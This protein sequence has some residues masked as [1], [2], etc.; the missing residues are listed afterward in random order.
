MISF[1]VAQFL[2]QAKET[3]TD[4]TLFFTQNLD[5]ILQ[6]MPVFLFVYLILAFFVAYKFNEERKEFFKL[7]NLMRISSN[8]IGL[9]TELSRLSKT[10]LILLFYNLYM[11]L[12]INFL[13]SNLSTEQTVVDTS[14]FIKDK[15]KL[16]TTD[17]VIC[18]FQYEIDYIL[19]SGSPKGTF[20]RKIF[21]MKQFS[22]PF[23]DENGRLH[24]ECIFSAEALSVTSLNLLFRNKLSKYFILMNRTTSLVRKMMCV[25]V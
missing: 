17:K 12:F 8:L 19:A 9:N 25:G 20:F 10:G 14:T 21:D 23:K 1:Q 13:T 16:L 18:W 15:W 6:L 4:L 24:H 2:D 11:F 7:A 22:P 3:S 5:F